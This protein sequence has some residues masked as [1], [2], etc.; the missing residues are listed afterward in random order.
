MKTPR[1]RRKDDDLEHE[2]QTHLAMAARDREDRG[3]P[4]DDARA[5]S[6]REFGNVALVKR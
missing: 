6:R 4:S 1:W 2:I 5:D 3:Q